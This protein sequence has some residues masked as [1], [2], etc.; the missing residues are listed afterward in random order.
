MGIEGVKK[1]QK[2]G[3]V[4]LGMRQKG[5][6]CDLALLTFTDLWIGEMT[7]FRQIDFSNTK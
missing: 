1:S 3:N 4:D 5:L 2:V 6:Q 7:H